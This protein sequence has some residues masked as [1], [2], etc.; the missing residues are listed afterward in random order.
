[1]NRGAAFNDTAA[2]ARSA[3]RGAFSSD[4]RIPLIGLRP[5]R[6]LER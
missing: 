1:V 3:A 5:A 2:L 6:A 4:T